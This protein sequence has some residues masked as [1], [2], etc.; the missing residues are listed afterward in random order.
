MD[1]RLAHLL[2]AKNALRERWKQQKL[3]RRL[4]SKLTELN[5]KIE[6]HSRKLS[7]QQWDEV[8]NEA[9]GKMRRGNKWGFLK[10][11]FADNK[12][13]QEQCPDNDREPHPPTHK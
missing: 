1:S 4:R 8:C 13:D 11:L 9:D 12:T 7:A 2:E 6:E 10:N 5:K 3:K